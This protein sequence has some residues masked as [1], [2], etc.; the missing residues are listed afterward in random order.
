MSWP[1]RGVGAIVSSP[2]AMG[3][4]TDRYLDGIPRSSHA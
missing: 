1:A 4:L 2:L 3:L